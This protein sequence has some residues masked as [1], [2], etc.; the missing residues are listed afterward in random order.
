[1]SKKKKAHRKPEVEKQVDYYS[2]HTQAVRDLAE[3]DESNSPEVPP[4]VLRSYQSGARFK[5]ADWVKALFIKFWFPGAV[6]FFFIWGLGNAV[7]D[8]LDM[9]VITGIAL[10]MVTDLLTNNV[11]RFMEKTP[12]ANDRWMMFPAKKFITFPLNI[13]YSFVVL[14]MVYSIYTVINATAAAVTGD[15]EHIFL[16]VEPICFGLFY[17]LC[18]MLLIEIKHLVLRLVHSGAKKQTQ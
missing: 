18:D 9:L 16:G 2:L 8:Q 14:A 6:C 4:E 13:L 10:G 3:A 17:D 11:L 5:I 12:G 7:Q 15:P 1:M